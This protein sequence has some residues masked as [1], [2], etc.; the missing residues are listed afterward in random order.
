VFVSP[1]C[2]LIVGIEVGESLPS[3]ATILS[4]IVEARGYGRK[5]AMARARLD[6]SS[7]V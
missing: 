1:D 6:K 4:I 5:V 2:F 3:P 7:Y